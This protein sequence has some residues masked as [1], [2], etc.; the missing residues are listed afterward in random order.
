MKIKGGVGIV[1]DDVGL[2]WRSTVLYSTTQ[3]TTC[4]AL[5]YVL[6]VMV[7]VFVKKSLEYFNLS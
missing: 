4:S 7:S 6:T 3:Y 5:H 1:W 2:F